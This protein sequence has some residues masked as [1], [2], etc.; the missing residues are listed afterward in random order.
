MDGL[1]GCGAACLASG[2]QDLIPHQGRAEL[3]GE[4]EETLDRFYS[5]ADNRCAICWCVNNREGRCVF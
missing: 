5:P 1:G 2:T 3:C 4:Q